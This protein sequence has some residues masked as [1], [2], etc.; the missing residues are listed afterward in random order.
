M[1]IIISALYY[2]GKEDMKNTRFH[3]EK[4]LQE[5]DDQ[6]R[7]IKI[8]EMLKEI[9]KKKSNEASNETEKAPKPY[10]QQFIRY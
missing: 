6:G 10:R 3:L 2:S 7:K 1:L 4:A 5:T 9:K 8:E